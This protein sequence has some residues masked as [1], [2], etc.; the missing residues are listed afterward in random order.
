MSATRLVPLV[1]GV[2]SA[3]IA[4]LYIVIM[5]RQPDSGDTFSVALITASFASAAA[6]LLASAWARGSRERVAL[7]T[8]GATVALFWTL[9][10]NTL[11]PLWLPIAVLGWVA[12]IRAARALN[13]ESEGKRGWVVL[14]GTWAVCLAV[15]ALI[16]GGTITSHQSAE[17]GSGQGIAAPR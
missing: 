17:S 2:G 15:L 1:A 9:L 5:I 3:V 10:L 4:V 16:V 12:A 6:T 11:T 14:G 8:W 7:L 13:R